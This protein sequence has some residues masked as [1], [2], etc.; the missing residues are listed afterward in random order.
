LEESVGFFGNFKQKSKK[1]F[2]LE[3]PGHPMLD[4][5]R[6]AIDLRNSRHNPRHNELSVQRKFLKR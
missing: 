6:E 5:I 3:L 4:S 2:R 1:Y